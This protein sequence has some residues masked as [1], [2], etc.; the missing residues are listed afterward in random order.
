MFA[1]IAVSPVD[2]P[3]FPGMIASDRD[4][5]CSQLAHRSIVVRCDIDLPG[6]LS[7]SHLALN[8]ASEP[9]TRYQHDV[10]MDVATALCQRL[11]LRTVTA[12]GAVDALRLQTDFGP[13]VSESSIDSRRETCQR[14]KL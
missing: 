13:F 8:L 5:R 4:A 11:R 2:F 12:L 7:S 9:A 10:W 14:R 1:E 6:P 3:L